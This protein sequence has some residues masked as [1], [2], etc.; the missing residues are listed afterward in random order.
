MPELITL[1]ARR[2]GGLIPL[3]RFLKRAGLKGLWAGRL[4]AIGQGTEVPP[5][6]LLEQIG[7]ACAVP[8]LTQARHDWF[9]RY[10]AQLQARRLSPVGVEV[11]LL[12]A[13][14][15]VTLRELGPKLGFNYSVLVRDLQRLDRDEPIKWFHIERIL[16]AVDLAA[17]DLRWREIHALWYTAEERR[18]NSPTRPHQRRHASLKVAQV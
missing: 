14:T 3:M 6:R 1:L 17:D 10:R 9:D 12:I 8:D 11:R 15:A 2:E 18:K 4:R 13:E 16:R 5:W 7:L